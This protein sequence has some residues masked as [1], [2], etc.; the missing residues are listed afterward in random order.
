[1]ETNMKRFFYTF[2]VFTLATVVAGC[3]S[4]E[5]D[6]YPARP[7]TL[8]VGFAEGGGSDQWA[9]SIASAAERTLGVNINVTNVVGNGG[10]NALDEY[11]TQP[12]DGYSLVSIV[13]IYAAAYAKRE[14]E[15]NPAE[16]VIPLL[17]GNMV[18]SQMYIA[19]DD[20]RFS[21]WQEV[22]TYAQNNPGMTVA[23]AG[24]E[25]D[26]EGV[27][28]LGL[29]NAFGIDL[30]REIIDNTNDRFS[31]PISGTT[32]LLIEQVSD[33]QEMIANGELLPVLTLWNTRP[34]GHEDVLAVTELAPDY[35]SLVRMRGLAAHAD[36]I[37]ERLEILREALRDAFNSRGFQADLEDRSLDLIPYPEDA[38]S[39][40][41]DQITTYESFY[42]TELGVGCPSKM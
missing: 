36:V 12:A 38:V 34:T 8:Y 22:V 18:I 31:A 41:R 29:E 37:P 9:R 27:S 24:V 26:M 39:A 42:C 32:D 10:L 33:V 7:I 11:I 17:V 40:F 20:P 21:T 1:M 25:L 23:S 28:I 15:I 3:S 13:D 5:V 2:V 35:Q 19:A 30:E 14:T 16:D 4:Q 6:D